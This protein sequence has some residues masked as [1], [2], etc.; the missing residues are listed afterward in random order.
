MHIW[1]AGVNLD[2]SINEQPMCSALMVF[3]LGSESESCHNSCCY[4][5]SGGEHLSGYEAV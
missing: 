4:E 1:L 3:V 5:W 2:V